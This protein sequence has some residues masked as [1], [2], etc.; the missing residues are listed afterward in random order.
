LGQV[1]EPDDL[2]P[3][4]HVGLYRCSK[5]ERMW[6]KLLTLKMNMYVSIKLRCG[7]HWYHM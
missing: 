4:L 6:K 2:F 5:W 3:L 1:D 7:H